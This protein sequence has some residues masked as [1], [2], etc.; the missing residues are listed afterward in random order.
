MCVHGHRV[1]LQAQAAAENAQ[2]QQQLEA[3]RQA[4]TKRQQQESLQAK[5]AAARII[6][7]VPQ[8]A[9]QQRLVV[10]RELQELVDAR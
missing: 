9:Q 3:Q 1:R 7:K 5:H 10:L 6:Q 8:Q 4:N 2:T